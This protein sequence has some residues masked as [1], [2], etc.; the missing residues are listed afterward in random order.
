MCELS[1]DRFI[2]WL[3]EN[4]YRRGHCCSQLLAG[5]E[6]VVFL[7]CAAR[8]LS[9]VGAPSAAASFWLILQQQS[10]KNLNTVE[11]HG[12]RQFEHRSAHQKPDIRAI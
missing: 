2:C 8:A 11:R 4:L 1:M 6:Y 9:T 5:H 12:R 10:V 3:K 7:F